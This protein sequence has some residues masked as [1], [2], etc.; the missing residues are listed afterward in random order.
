MLRRPRGLAQHVHDLT[1]CSAGDQIVQALLQLQ[2]VVEPLQQRV[3]GQD[4]LLPRGLAP[5]R[6]GDAR[7]DIYSL[8]VMLYECL[9]GDVPFRGD[10]EWEVLRK[11]ESEEVSFPDHLVAQDRQIIARCLAKDPLDRYESV[12]ELLRDLQAPVALGESLLIRAAPVERV[13]ESRPPEPK[14]AMRPPVLGDAG[15]ILLRDPADS[16]YQMP[17]RQSQ[18]SSNRLLTFLVRQVFSVFELVIFVLMLP[19][20]LLSG[21]SGRGLSWLFELPLQLLQFAVRVLGLT[22]VIALIALMVVG[23]VLLAGAL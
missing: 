6:R 8:G 18:P 22:L 7:S 4:L 21:A 23:V 17:W 3:L 13:A 2:E 1:D 9:C 14:Q 12:A 16:P 11:H 10:S 19:V 20:R 5:Q 15:D